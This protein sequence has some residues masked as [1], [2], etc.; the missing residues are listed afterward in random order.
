LLLVAGLWAQLAGLA[1]YRG[2]ILI[3]AL[4]RSSQQLLRSSLAEKSCHGRHFCES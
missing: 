3:F 1:A 2:P 4:H